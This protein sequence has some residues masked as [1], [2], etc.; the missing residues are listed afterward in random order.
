MNAPS[1]HSR[2][3][4]ANRMRSGELIVLGTALKR[5]SKPVSGRFN[6]DQRLQLKVHRLCSWR[7]GNGAI[8][9]QET[10]LH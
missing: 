3:H 1:D 6:C 10:S 8:D 5:V 7:I 9:P 2:R 4:A